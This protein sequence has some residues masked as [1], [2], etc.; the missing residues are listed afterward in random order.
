MV[1]GLESK[2]RGHP[3]DEAY[4]FLREAIL[5]WATDEAE[6][7]EVAERI[8]GLGKALWRWLLLVTIDL[9]PRDKVVSRGV[10]GNERAVVMLSDGS[11]GRRS[12]RQQ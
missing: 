4:R 3:I 7:E 5:D 12:G 9:E 11:S 6:A 8:A 1:S 2:L 10:V